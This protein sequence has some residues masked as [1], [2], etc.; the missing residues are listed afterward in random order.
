MSN[1]PEIYN[2]TDWHNGGDGV[3]NNLHNIRRNTPPSNPGRNSSTTDRT[4]DCSN[5]R[6]SHPSPNR[7]P[8]GDHTRKSTRDCN[9]NTRDHTSR[10]TTES[11]PNYYPCLYLHSHWYYR[12]S[13]RYHNHNCN[14]RHSDTDRLG[15]HR[16]S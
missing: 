7:I 3:P 16:Q 13:N 14:I 15:L 8:N 11:I 2:Y 1:V 9:Y 5:R 10:N 4:K 6:R 12:P